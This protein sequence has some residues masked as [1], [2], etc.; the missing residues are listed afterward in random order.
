MSS[1]RCRGILLGFTPAYR[2]KIDQLLAKPNGIVLVTGLTG[3]GESTTLYT[4]LSAL[5]SIHR[6]IVTIE[7]PVE[8]KP[9]EWCRSR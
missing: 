1:A 3:S 4:F 8:H 6:R 5:N 2:A 9:R 7:D